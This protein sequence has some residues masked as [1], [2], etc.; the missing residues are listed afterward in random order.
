MFILVFNVA[1]LLLKSNYQY[2]RTFLRVHNT[3]TFFRIKDRVFLC[4]IKFEFKYKTILDTHT[5]KFKI[6][7]SFWIKS[8]FT[9]KSRV[10]Q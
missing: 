4:Y 6:F 8:L 1:L 2:Y 3:N 7:L 9:N 10:P 5:L